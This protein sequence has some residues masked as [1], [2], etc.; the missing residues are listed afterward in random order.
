MTAQLQWVSPFPLFPAC[1]QTGN[2]EFVASQLHNA[3]P[4]SSQCHP[5]ME[6]GWGDHGVSE[7]WAQHLKNP[8]QPI[9]NN[10]SARGLS[11]H[12]TEQT[13]AP[14][15]NTSSFPSFSTTA[16]CAS[17]LSNHTIHLPCPPLRCN[18]LL[19]LFGQ[20]EEEEWCPGSVW[21]LM[22]LLWGE[23]NCKLD[24]APSSEFSLIYGILPLFT[25]SK[26]SYNFK[27]LKPAILTPKQALTEV[28]EGKAGLEIFW[29][30]IFNCSSLQKQ[31]NFH[32][33]QNNP[34]VR[35]CVC[36][37]ECKSFCFQVVY[38]Y[39]PGSCH[40]IHQKKKQIIL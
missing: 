4:E 22:L 26:G 38:K 1:T 28:P 32:F 24:C 16:L 23:I 10:S 31:N 40:W 21:Q 9:R 35:F 17:K 3:V 11:F 6:M 27:S 5:G 8:N 19:S 2:S 34:Y 13:Q 14:Q 30:C 36:A 15:N 7:Q 12:E 29:Q 39:R 25:H 18:S 20:G 33:L 37:I